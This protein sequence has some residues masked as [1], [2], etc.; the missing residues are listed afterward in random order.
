MGTQKGMIAPTV[1]EERI[2]DGGGKNKRFLLGW[3]GGDVPHDY[4]RPLRTTAVTP[5]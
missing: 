1:P 3:V 2:M 5:R 4:I